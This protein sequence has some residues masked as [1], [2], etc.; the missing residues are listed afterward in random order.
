MNSAYR[1]TQGKEA[2]LIDSKSNSPSWQTNSFSSNKEIIRILRNPT[3]LD[4]LHNI[5]PP[6]PILSL[7]T[8]V[9]ALPFTSSSWKWSP[10]PTFSIETLYVFL[11]HTCHMPRLTHPP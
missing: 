5:L 3:A 9:H 11:P 7:V 1:W 8:P 6:V 10:S 4:H 2:Y